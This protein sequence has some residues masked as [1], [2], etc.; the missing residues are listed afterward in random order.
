MLD[1]DVD[2][3]KTFQG[4]DT[5]NLRT[6]QRLT[7]IDLGTGARELL[8]EALLPDRAVDTRGPSAFQREQ[9][10][11]MSRGRS[12]GPWSKPDSGCLA[13]LAALIT[14]PAFDLPGPS[15]HARQPSL[16]AY[17]LGSFHLAYNLHSVGPWPS[18]KG[19][20]I[21][22]Y[23][24]L[25]YPTPVSKDVLMD[26]FWPDD[27]PLAARRNLHQAIYAMRQVLG[28]HGLSPQSAQFGQDHYSLDPRPGLWSDVA[29]FEKHV[30]AG[31]RY[32]VRDQ[33]EA[34][35]A[36]Y[37]VA[38]GLYQGDL[39]EDELYED[40]PRWQRETLRSTY[41]DIADRLGEYYLQ[42]RDYPATMAL[43]W[44]ILTF[45]PCHEHAHCRLMKC[46]AAQGQR[47]MAVRQYHLCA[48]ALQAGL[49]LAP[50]GG[51]TA[52][53]RQLVDEG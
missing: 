13:Q 1:V 3:L 5:A 15:P 29:E 38:Q 28:K 39:L 51:T 9:A 48:D 6:T 43:S 21:L 41:L 52:L 8:L 4:P 10:P 17:C 42:V 36:E 27:E 49:D 31:R 2:L 46:Y 23:L 53:Y 45:D 16:A 44:R 25:H 26:V 30:Q 11:A 7:A 18:R 32:E 35:M 40:W 14:S 12:G 47:H 24:I 50:S 34:A 33:V 19:L 22:E 37:E 20:G